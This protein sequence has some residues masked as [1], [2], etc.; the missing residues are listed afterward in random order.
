V[1]EELSRAGCA[2]WRANKGLMPIG[3]RGERLNNKCLLLSGSG[4][5]PSGSGYWG[6]QAVSGVVKVV[7]GVVKRV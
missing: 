7:T 6:S 4:D 1:A 5:R 2:W 3:G